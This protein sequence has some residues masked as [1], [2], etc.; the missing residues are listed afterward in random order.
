MEETPDRDSVIELLETL[1]DPDD[2]AA[3]AAARKLHDQVAASGLTWDDLLVPDADAAEPDEQWD[4]EDG[5]ESAASEPIDDAVVPSGEAAGDLALIDRL[6]ARKD[7]SSDFR[8]ELDGYKDD[9]KEGEFTT[10]DRTYLQAL[11]N[12]LGKPSK[13]RGKD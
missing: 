7:I 10:A 11:S 13:S 6:L 3:L 4:D 2:A 12:R 1:G 5:D 8:E 9:I